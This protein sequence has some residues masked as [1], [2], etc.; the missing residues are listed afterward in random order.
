MQKENEIEIW[1]RQGIDSGSDAAWLLKIMN[2]R[3]HRPVDEPAWRDQTVRDSPDCV[4][5]YRAALLAAFKRGGNKLS[6]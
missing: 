5:R 4:V 3:G 2:R 1:G 6:L